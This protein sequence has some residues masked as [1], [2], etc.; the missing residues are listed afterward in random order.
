MF[1]LN[2]NVLFIA[3]D[4]FDNAM[5]SLCTLQT[6]NAIAD[7]VKSVFMLCVIDMR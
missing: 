3:I 2:S 6:V 5:L 7:N 4:N 1:L